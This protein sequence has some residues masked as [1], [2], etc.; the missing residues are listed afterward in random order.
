MIYVIKMVQGAEDGKFNHAHLVIDQ[1]YPQNGP[2]SALV[3]QN[4]VLVRIAFLPRRL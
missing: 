4:K 1:V 3:G 2:A